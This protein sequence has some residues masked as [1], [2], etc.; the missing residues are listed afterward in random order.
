MQTTIVRTGQADR[1]VGMK[2]KRG[3]GG[4]VREIEKGGG[5]TDREGDR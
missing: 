3:E 4:G 1:C 2:R 5:E